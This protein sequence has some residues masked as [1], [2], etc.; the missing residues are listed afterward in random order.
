MLTTW[1]WVV[2]FIIKNVI[3][4]FA[5]MKEL[6]YF[7]YINIISRFSLSGFISKWYSTSFIFTYT[8]RSDVLKLTLKTGVP[9]G[10]CLHFMSNLQ[11]EK[12]MS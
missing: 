11:V 8:M 12:T 6:L 9:L 5:C 1:E 3:F 4:D 7:Q 2:S 10:I